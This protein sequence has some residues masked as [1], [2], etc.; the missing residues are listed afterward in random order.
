MLANKFILFFSFF[1]FYTKAK[2]CWKDE[3]EAVA[4]NGQ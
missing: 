4:Y 2:F 3:D 1:F